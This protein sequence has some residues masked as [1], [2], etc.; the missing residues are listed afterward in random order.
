LAVL[1][2]KSSPQR[3]YN[4]AIK[5]SWEEDMRTRSIQ[6][7][8]LTVMAVVATA[9]CASRPFLGLGT[10]WLDTEFAYQ[11]A[12]VTEGVQDL[13]ALKPELVALLRAPEVQGLSPER[14]IDYVVSTILK[15][16]TQPFKYRA[17]HST[18][19]SETWE[20]RQGDCL[21]LTVLTYA[22]TKELRLQP[23]MQ[24]VSV[25]ASFDR[26]NGVDYL[27]GH[28]NLFIGNR[29]APN[30][31]TT[32]GMER[33]VLIDFE[34]SSLGSVRV[35]EALSEQSMLARYYNNRGAELMAL[36]DVPTAYAY[37]KAAIGADPQF[38]AAQT[39]LAALYWQQG[40][41]AQAERLL[42]NV[43]AHSEQADVAVRSLQRMMLAQGRT[44]DAD[45]YQ[46]MLLAR[47]EQDPYY[48]IAAGLSE[49]Q[50]KE[51]L[52][53]IR[54][55]EKAEKLTTGFAEIH[56]YLALAYWFNG[57]RGKAQEQLGTLAAINREDPSLAQLSRKF[58][59]H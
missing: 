55:L 2:L 42:T 56:R 51:Y 28:V 13:F 39:N 6:R 19:A 27:I 36:A 20:K 12:L 30:K 5:S 8:S 3:A 9:G 54:A 58:R 45:R 57:Q 50:Q 47:R 17:G 49:Y 37:F 43:V 46:T 16:N 40:F 34:P 26:R 38:V 7:C 44:A 53:A 48:W 10:E 15:S 59:A 18:R 24:E 29:G 35:R 4:R 25:P 32:P 31:S 52:N 33:G 41:N 22:L 11:P 23:V 1:Q 14:R 21:S